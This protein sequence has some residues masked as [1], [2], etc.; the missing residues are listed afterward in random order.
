[1]RNKAKIVKTSPADQNN[2]VL[3]VVG[4]SGL[5]R[6]KPCGGCPFKCENRGSFPAEAFRISA[7][8]SYDMAQNTFAC[9]EQGTDKPAIC[10]GFL[11]VAADNNMS[12]RIG[13]MRK[14]IDMRQVHDDGNELYES[15]HHMAVDNGVD[16]EDPV[17][18][19]C[20]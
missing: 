17:L 3:T 19:E 16:P 10:A 7:S 9:H 15:Y 20:R 8:T 4:G 6:R 11:L 13:I 14:K 2:Q 1:M 18:K 5:Y 12:V